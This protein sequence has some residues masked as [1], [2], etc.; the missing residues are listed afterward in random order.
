MDRQFNANTEKSRVGILDFMDSHVYP[1]ESTGAEQCTALGNR[2][3]W[4]SILIL[5]EL[6]AGARRHGLWNLFL[7]GEHS[8]GPTNL[9]CAPLAETLGRSAHFA[10]FELSCS[11][12][13]ICSELRRQPGWRR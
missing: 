11:A 7:P 9:Q 1:V 12:P 8:D 10:P 6:R 13:D 5:T 4:D 3:A 2:G